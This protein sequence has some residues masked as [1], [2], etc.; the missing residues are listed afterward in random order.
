MAWAM[1]TQSKIIPPH[2][3]ATGNRIDRPQ[4]GNISE[5][6]RSYEFLGMTF[7]P[8]TREQTVERAMWVTAQHGF[9]Y[10]VTPNVDH[11][12]NTPRAAEDFKPAFSSAWLSV[13]DSRI[14]ELL[15][16]FVGIPLHAVPGSDLTRNIIENIRD[17]DTPVTMI[18]GNEKVARITA[19][20][21]GLSNIA[22]HVPPMG[23]R[24]N[25]EAI[26]ACAKFMSDNPARY[27]FICVGSPQQEMIAKAAL[28]RGDCTGLGFCVGASL[29][30]LAG[31]QSRAPKWMQRSRLEWLYRLCKE[32]KRMWR[33]YLIDGPSV[34]LIYAKWIVTSRKAK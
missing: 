5:N 31:F 21:Y 2:I 28:D 22:V 3:Q 25:R 30:F 14:L 7:Q 29:D 9:R 23:L 17:S 6:T 11:V 24:Q 13:C 8:L 33:R 10:I 1:N 34:F 19:E 4:R 12:V 26:E 32:P 20:K 15:A 27:H 18:V 16:K